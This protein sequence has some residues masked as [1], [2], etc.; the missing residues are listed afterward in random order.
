MKDKTTMAS[1]MGNGIDRVGEFISYAGKG[2]W[3]SSK[4]RG[5]CERESI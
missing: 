1:G 2:G 3:D 5:G 4:T